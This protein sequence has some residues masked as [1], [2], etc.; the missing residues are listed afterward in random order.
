[1]IAS[2]NWSKNY[3]P[4]QGLIRVENAKTDKIFDRVYK[5]LGS[6]KGG[7][8]AYMLYQSL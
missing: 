2:A 4:L 7:T 1:M 8:C 6:Y 5:K 3:M